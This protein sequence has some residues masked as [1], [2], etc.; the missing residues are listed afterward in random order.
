MNSKPS[1]RTKH[2]KSSPLPLA[3]N[4]HLQQTTLLR[5]NLKATR[6]RYRQAAHTKTETIPHSTN[7]RRETKKTPSESPWNAPRETSFVKAFALAEAATIYGRR[8]NSRGEL[9]CVVQGPCHR[10]PLWY[11]AFNGRRFII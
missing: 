1:I 10:R 6:F 5:S 11:N 2:I 8:A 4:N 9:S 3:L 7:N